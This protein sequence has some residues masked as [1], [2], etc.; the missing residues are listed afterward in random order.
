MKHAQPIVQNPLAPN[1]QV[2]R[3]LRPILPKPPGEAQQYY[4]TVPGVC[5]FANGKTVMPVVILPTNIYVE[6]ASKIANNK[7]NDLPFTVTQGQDSTIKVENNVPETQQ[8]T[9]ATGVVFSS[10]MEE[11]L[12]NKN[13][14]EALESIKNESLTTSRGNFNES[15]ENFEPAIKKIK[16]ENNLTPCPIIHVKKTPLKDRTL[17]TLAAINAAPSNDSGIF[18]K[19][20]KVQ[21]FTSFNLTPAHLST[22]KGTIA[23]SKSDV[24]SPS[25]L[26]TFHSGLTPLKYDSDSGFFTPLREADFDFLLSPNQLSLD[27]LTPARFNSTPQG[28][29]K[30]LKLGTVHEEMTDSMTWMQ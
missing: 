7:K 17:P 15:Q 27:Q 8:D 20:Y 16:K 2:C 13:F 29:R 6:L 9:N 23:A 12:R 26:S 25:P 5:S 30:S 19:D 22:P 4:D 24:Q 21:D 28:C 14:S 11:I 1:G 3:N 18:D 10:L